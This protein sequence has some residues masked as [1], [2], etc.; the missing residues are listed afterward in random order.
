MIRFF[1]YLFNYICNLRNRLNNKNDLLDNDSAD[2]ITSSV[3]GGKAKYLWCTSHIGSWFLSIN[4]DGKSFKTKAT[5][6]TDDLPISVS[7]ADEAKDLAEDSVLDF[8]IVDIY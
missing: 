2:S 4:W 1:N 8:R 6:G 5:N 7:L 3:L